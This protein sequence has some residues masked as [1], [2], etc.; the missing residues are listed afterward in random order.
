MTLR[1]I[2]Q[3]TQANAFGELPRIGRAPHVTWRPILNDIVDQFRNSNADG[4]FSIALR[5]SAARGASVEEAADLDLVVLLGESATSMGQV[6]S[7]AAPEVSIETA[8]VPASDFLTHLDWVWMRFTLAHCGHTAFGHDHLSDLPEPGLGPHCVAHLRD[9]DRWLKQWKI[10]W[11]QDKDYLAIC[12]WL[13]KRIV[14]SLFE[15]QLE[16]IN[17]Y[18]RD[19]YPCAKVAIQAFPDLRG[20]ILDAAELAVAPVDDREVISKIC[21]ELTPVLLTRQLEIK[22]NTHD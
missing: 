2:G 9:A 7:N 22:N 21:D 11:D 12:E 19:I 5:G 20:A 1:S 16:Q 18:T 14:R 17:G 4:T 8:Y 3:L 15:S 13:M 6:Q 10:Y